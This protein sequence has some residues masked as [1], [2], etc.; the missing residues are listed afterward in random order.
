MAATSAGVRPSSW[1]FGLT[2][3]EAADPWVDRAGAQLP[4]R[5]G[6]PCGRQTP[7]GK[8]EGRELPAGVRSLHANKAVLLQE[9]IDALLAYAP[10]ELAY[11]RGVQLWAE[12]VLPG[13]GGGREQP[14]AAGG[15]YGDALIAGDSP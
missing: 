4:E 3:Q 1:E 9:L 10:E 13:G 8:L 2:H 6:Q 7:V 15:L 14:G 12:G 11:V 5:L